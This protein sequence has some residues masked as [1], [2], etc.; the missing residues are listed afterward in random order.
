MI[1]RVDLGNNIAQFVVSVDRN[2]GRRGSIDHLRRHVVNGRGDTGS[3]DV[4]ILCSGAIADF[5]DGEFARAIGC[6]NQFDAI[7]AVIDL[8]VYAYAD[9]GVDATDNV[10]HRRGDI[11]LFVKVNS[12]DVSVRAG[13]FEVADIDP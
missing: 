12:A 8:G 9:Q 11:V 2:R 6:I 3:Q 4:E 1:E 10:A 5:G 13:D 7:A